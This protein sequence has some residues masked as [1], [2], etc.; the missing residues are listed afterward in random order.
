VDGAGNRVRLVLL[1]PPGAGKGTQAKLLQE[2]FDIPQISTGDILRH[3]AK[4]GTRLG[5]QAKKYMDRG[6]LVPDPVILDIVDERL[7]ADDARKGFLLDGFPRTVAQ[8][9]AF[10][11]MLNRRQE[12]LDGAISLRVPRATVVARLS[13]RR[14]CRQCGA[15]Y[16]VRFNPPAKEGV[17]DQCGGDLYQRADDREETIEARMEVYDRESAPLLDYFRDKGLLREVDGSKSTDEVFQ[18][19]LRQLRKAA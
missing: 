13:G 5:K 16:H 6:E 7:S 19:I 12:T 1:G 11:T 8:A 14:T 18:Q 10:E 2:H 9:E 15:M 3:A 4:E 17:C